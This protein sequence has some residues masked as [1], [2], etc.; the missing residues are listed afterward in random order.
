[1]T[2]LRSTPPRLTGFTFVDH[3]GEG[4]FADVFLY[5]DGLNRQVAVKVLLESAVQA[6]ERDVFHA[7]ANLMAQLS[8]HPSI[9]SIFQAGV[10]D[11]G[12]PYLVMEYCPA[13]NLA[14]RYRAE[15]FSVPDTLEIGVRLCSAVET[16]HRAGILHRDIKPHNILTSAYGSP[17]LTDFGIAATTHDTDTGAT[18][19]SVPWSPPE[20]F[21]DDPPTDVRS[22]V[23]SLGATLYTLLAGRSPFEVPGAAN[24][25]ATLMTRIERQQPAR[26]NRGD[27]P[28]SLMTILT[29]AMSKDLEARQPSALALASALYDV[30]LELGEPP[31]RIEVLDASATDPV[32]P[33][34][35]DRT[36]VR[37]VAVVEPQSKDQAQPEGTRLRPV[38]I[39]DV[40]DRTHVRPLPSGPPV[41]AAPSA[42]T[43]APSGR[44]A[45]PAGPASPAPAPRPATPAAGPDD[46]IPWHVA[47]AL[48]PVAAPPAATTAPAAERDRRSPWLWVGGLVVL[49]VIAGLVAA[50][51]LNGTSSDRDQADDLDDGQRQ[52]PTV[53]VG[54]APQA[55]TDLE[56][57][58][59]EGLAVFT[60]TNPD[61]EAGDTY[62]WM[63][64]GAGQLETAN[65]VAEPTLTIRAAGTGSTCIVVLV[66]RADGRTSPVEDSGPVCAR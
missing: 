9:V 27:V 2:R 51:L 25:N 20:F 22:D 53:V 33:S 40:D 45:P 63:R 3:I 28:D 42:P 14:A 56:G 26:I 1:M 41:P 30:Q 10:S 8:D 24:D 50:A 66:K 58:L 43:P 55:P 4:G 18:G 44:V 65:E 17:M 48:A 52:D 57:R 19:V 59:Q 61:P 15:R 62:V 38:V 54:D 21:G 16:A 7:E 6:A 29:T 49:L 36:R 5:R 34:D 13:P 46:A 60:W 32:T 64:A 39:S 31:T 11:D 37:P 47:S 23:W 12:R 35:D